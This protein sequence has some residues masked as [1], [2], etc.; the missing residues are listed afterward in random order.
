MLVEK[1]TLWYFICRPLWQF[2]NDFFSSRPL[3]SLWYN[4]FILGHR[5]KMI[6]SQTVT[7]LSLATKMVTRLP[8]FTSS[9]NMSVVYTYTGGTA[10]IDCG[11]NLQGNTKTWVW[12]VLMELIL[13]MR[14]V[15]NI[16]FMILLVGKKISLLTCQR[17]ISI[18]FSKKMKRKRQGMNRYLISNSCYQ[19][20]TSK[21]P[22]KVRNVSNLYFSL[23]FNAKYGKCTPFNRIPT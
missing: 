22:L 18:D 14:I 9:S 12:K 4:I 7:P 5:H 20:W 13:G 17:R 1:P 19:V 15:L 3:Y 8:E 23:K 6:D 10:H 11:V 16:R 2:L 21:F